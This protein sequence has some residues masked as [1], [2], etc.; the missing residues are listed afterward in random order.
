[1]FI[2]KIVRWII[3][4]ITISA[5]GAFSERFLNLA[6]SEGIHVWN[7]KREDETKLSM[8]VR[9]GDFKRIQGVAR[10]ASCRVRITDRTGLRFIM[11]KHRKRK[12]FLIS[13][14]L[15]FALVCFLS[16]LIWGV[17]LEG[18]EFT[19]RAALLESLSEA[20]L[21]SGAP[22][23]SLDIPAIQNEILMRHEDIAWIGI[24]I[25]G[26]KAY[27]K[28]EPRTLP[29]ETPKDD[30]ARNLVSDF[31]AVVESIQ[32]YEGEAA[33][34]KGEAVTKGQLLVSGVVD[35]EEGGT[36]FLH[37]EAEVYGRVWISMHKSIP[38]YGIKKIYTGETLKKR[39]VKAAG[40][41]INL[42]INSSIPY[43]KYDKIIREEEMKIGVFELPAT[44]LTADIREYEEETY[45][46]LW[47][48]ARD[49]LELECF[50]ELRSLYP[51]AA[52]LNRN[53]TFTKTGDSYIMDAEYEC[54]M[55][56]AVSIEI[57]H[58]KATEE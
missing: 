55:P 45:P 11:F 15:F 57:M 44:Y 3:S 24:N 10:R 8:C 12:A 16:T 50:L 46:L 36:R 58:D 25:K 47:D 33:V 27:V 5:Q 53:I 20:G 34:K 18:A 17:E 23:G 56:I 1:M 26:T 38:F 9:V 30:A 29:P 42:F 40:V 21:R 7:V 2:L 49:K 22:I 13:A 37:S 52:V 31:D 48:E 28:V 4:Y 43:D 39:A 19:D 32:V 14:V 6:G 51:E 35:L 41:K 54:V